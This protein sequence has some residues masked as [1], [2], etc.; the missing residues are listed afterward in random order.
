[1]N[2]DPQS[3][4]QDLQQTSTDPNIVAMAEA[5]IVR[6]IVMGSGGP[7]NGEVTDQGLRF[8]R[9]LMANSRACRGGFVPN[10]KNMDCI[11]EVARDFIRQCGSASRA[12][13]TMYQV[14]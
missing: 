9:H 8:V 1:M 7:D 11:K 2:F 6:M 13:Q 4:N 12:L 14:I 5:L 3:L 10:F